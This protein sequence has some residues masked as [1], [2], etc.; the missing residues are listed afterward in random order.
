M[1]TYFR[2]IDVA[3]AFMDSNG[4]PLSGGKLYTYSAG[5]TTNKATYQDNGGVT[6]HA[7]PIV[8]NASGYASAEV[9]GTTGAYK[10][11]L[12]NSADSNIWTRDNIV[13]INDTA[14][15]SATEWVSSGLTPTYVSATSFTVPGDQTTT[16]HAGRRLKIT[17]SGGTDY[18]TIT[19]SVYG[20]LTT[21]IVAVDGSGSIDSGISAV[22]YGL[23]ASA[24]SS[25]PAV[26]GWSLIDARTATAVATIDFEEGFY[27]GWDHLF[28]WEGIYPDVSDAL[29]IRVREGGSYISSA[30]AY[31]ATQVT[32]DNSAVAASS[33]QFTYGIIG[34]ATQA[35]AAGEAGTGQFEMRN[36]ASASL[37][38]RWNTQ[39]SLGVSSAA[40][41]FALGQ[42]SC[43]REAAA[44]CQGV[45]F[46]WSGGNNF[47]AAG[48]IK[49][50]RRRAT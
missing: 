33:G 16:L 47:A 43:E 14:E 34:Q 29:I 15:T 23:S 40:A 28:T 12:D 32:A 5:S 38:T 8:L 27:D 31:R 22:S 42:S 30:A 10:L 48:Y 20:A 45:R 25:N 21:L 41:R 7:N 11:K 9:W 3:R 24:N 6:P 44:A 19:S 13:G 37:Q 49:H 17:D 18:A 39:A 36:P 1:A 50:Y 46:L 2:L 26:N 4:D 35:A